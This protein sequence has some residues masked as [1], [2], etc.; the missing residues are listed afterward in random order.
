MSEISPAVERAV[1]SAEQRASLTPLRLAHLALSLLD[2]DEG[3]PAVLLQSLGVS[4]EAAREM[5]LA[6]A[7]TSP[8]APHVRRLYTAAR[9]W[10]VEHRADPTVL[11]DAF[12]IAVLQADEKFDRSLEPLGFSSA[13]LRQRLGGNVPSPQEEPEATPLG[14]AVDQRFNQAARVVD[15]NLNRAR[16]SLRVLDDYCRFVLDDRLLT[17]RFKHLRHRLAD[18]TSALP[19]HL[20]LAS[21]ETLLDV[22]TSVTASGEYQRESIGSVAAVNLK[23][24]Q[25]SLRSVEEFGKL[26]DSAFAQGIEQL[27]YEAYTLERAVVRSGEARERLANAVL[28]VLLTGAQCK[29]GLERTIAAAAAGGADVIQ[30]R[31]KDLSDRELLKRARDVRRWTR[32][33]GVLF[34]VNDRP[35]IAHLAEA[36]GVHL[37]Q[38]DLPV[39]DARRMLAPEALVGV[40]THSLD[41]VR[42]AVLDGA[43]YLGVGPTFPS[44][45]KSFDRLAGLEFIT[46]STTETSLPAFA[47]GGINTSTIDA[48]LQAGA[49]RVAVSAA[50]AGADDPEKAARALKRALRPPS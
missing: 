19:P 34:I 12:L 16:E 42:Q 7:E 27:R 26:L 6:S 2:D 9:E 8:A 50:I 39:H 21:R 5:L 4:L 25:E 49:R 30:L 28:Y 15:A 18:L 35:D 37:G 31:E 46:A 44:T 1:A 11:T 38:D 48:A 47:L 45:T 13:I 32:D 3:R 41:Q 24:L 36:D 22:G 17:E 20:L 14:E 10:S 23:R 43:D 29:H 33:A 40:S